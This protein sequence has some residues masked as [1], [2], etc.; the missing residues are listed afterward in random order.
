MKRC[1]LALALS[2]FAAVPAFGAE[3]TWYADADDDGYGDAATSITTEDITAPDGFVADA[4]DCDDDDA[5]V[6]PGADETCNTLDDDCDGTVDEAAIDVAPWHAD[7]DGDTYGDPDTFV[8]ACAPPTDHVANQ[9]DCDDLD[10]AIS[11]AEI[12]VCNDIDDNCD[13]VVDT[14]A[15]DRAAWYKD[16]DADTFGDAALPTLACDAPATYVANDD[17]C[18]DAAAAT[19]PDA[20]EVCN[21][22]DDDC[23][24]VVDTDATDRAVWYKD[25][26]ADAFGDAALTTLAC[27]APATYVGNDDDCDDA[28]AAVNPSAVEV[29][30]DIDDNCDTVVDTDAAD[31]AA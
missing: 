5:T 12:E 20:V 3:T 23:D 7:I 18:D 6:N 26:D 14:D 27:D 28:A 2:L 13:T 19:N 31:R 29:C 15:A 8:L 16:A 22:V 11:P 4:S 17:D 21:D 10:A 30:N 1:T 9:R 24:A 25:A